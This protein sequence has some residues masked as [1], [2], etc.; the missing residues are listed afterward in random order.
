MPELPQPT[1]TDIRRWCGEKSF[2]RGQRYFKEARILNPRRQGTTLKARCL[3][4][5]PQ[6]YYVEI[7]LDLNTKGISSG[8]CSC[9][10]GAG[11]Y[12]KHAAALLLAWR[13][14][15]QAFLQIEALE[16]ALKGRSQAELIALI[17]RMIKRHPDLETLL[18]LPIVGS[19]AAQSPLDTDVIRRQVD[20]VFQGIG[21]DW[22]ASYG[23]AA[24][25]E[26]LL[27]IGQD[28]AQ[29][30]DWRS[31]MTVYQIVAEKIL[32]AYGMFEDEGELADVVNLCVSGMGEC[33]EAASDPVQREAILRSLF[34]IYC[35]DVD[36]G[37]IGIGDEV[38][39]IIVEQSSIEETQ[40][41]ARWVQQALQAVPGDDSFSA[42]FQRRVYGGFLLDLGQDR[43][44]DEAFLRICRETDRWDDLVDRLLALGRV[45]EAVEVTQ[46]VSDYKL[47]SLANILVTHGQAGLAETLVRERAQSS[48]DDRLPSWLKQRALERGDLEQALALTEGLFWKSPSLAGYQ[49][50][51]ELAGSLGQWGELRSAVLARLADAGQ[52]GLL[53]AIHLEEGQVAQALETLAQIRRPSWH[54]GGES[55]RLQVARAAEEEYPQEAIRL[56]VPMAEKL[57]AARG[58]GNYAEATTY[59][60]RVRSLYHRL[61]EPVAWQ[62]LI[63]GI[64]ESNPRLRALKDELNKAGL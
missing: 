61:G 21:Y 35:W 13:H 25:L 1:E 31:A 49:E 46:Q 6:P 2:A 36:Y 7:T 5:Q 53:T 52:Y 48:R 16:S 10:I 34:D 12:C 4:S 51:R 19:A 29:R 60:V 33:L 63:R 18:E 15:P 9:P 45:E 17:C 8:D 28:Y 62:T 54:W 64:R 26:E 57:I 47:I 59:L 39:F 50:L 30:K 37:G 38:P 41:V 20:N 24:E 27:E 43:L 14:N 55:L 40:Q 32:A 11:G 3:G 23:A 44:D 22:G 42:S 58:R 56:Y